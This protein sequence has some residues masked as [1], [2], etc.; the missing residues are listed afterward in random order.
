[1]TDDGKAAVRDGG[2]A[3]RSIVIVGGGTAGWMAACLL[4]KRLDRQDVSITVIESHMI[5]TVGVGEA[6]VPAIRDYFRAIDLDEM[7]VLRETGGTIKLGIEFR[8][9][10]RPGHRFFH[11][12][13][14]YGLSSRGVPFHQ[15]WLKCLHAG[16]ERPLEDYS[17]CSELARRGLF[18][19]PVDNPVN[20]LGVFNWAVHF[21]AS[22]FARQLKTHGTAR[23]VRLVDDVIVD[24]RLDPASGHVRDVVTEGGQSVAGD[25]FIDCSGFRALLIGKALNTPWV[26]W[27][28]LLPC[29]R[30][31]AMP[32]ALD[33]ALDFPYT[34][35]TA[36]PAG[37]QWRIPLQHR[38]GNGYVYSSAHLSDDEAIADLRGRLEGEAL[39]EPNLI[40][41][42]AGHRVHFWNGNCVAV[43]L[44]AGF[45]E[46][47]E[48]TS[49]TL[50]QTAV[51]KLIDLFPDTG[52]DPALAAE[53]NRATT[54]EFERI[55]D[56]LILHYLGNRRLGEPMWD[57][58]RA[59]SPPD[60]LAHKL[61]LFQAR[62][63]LVRYEWEAFLDPSWLSMYAG[64]GM[65]PNR[66]D[67]MADH[68]TDAEIA[69]ALDRMREAIGAASAHA[70]PHGAFIAR[71]AAART[72]A[73]THPPQNTH[74]E[75]VLHG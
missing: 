9:W 29:D 59:A 64:F 58:L 49:I 36:R 40:R 54:L 73:Q 26:D 56:F 6:T 63:K 45:L 31:V 69:S 11:P 68:F 70:M 3:I 1:M 67:P 16:D 34:V 21:D 46:P 22:L 48:S 8:D 72:S 44:A 13:G 38:V 25:L 62:G 61:R 37:W 7:E 30:A 57:A 75:K 15:Y 41:F 20:E 28:D 53:Y 43:G 27:R 5:G 51:E 4:A 65:L 32:C 19:P 50:I 71:H 74:M 17:L 66:H 10:L 47:L 18:M 39:G 33:P 23:G 42:S 60:R 12:F 24:V 2:S 14:L 52:F 55:R 35:S